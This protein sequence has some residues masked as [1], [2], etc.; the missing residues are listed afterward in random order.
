MF[1]VFSILCYQNGSSQRIVINEI[2]ASNGSTIRDE[3]GQFEDYIELFN[4]DSVSI[5]LE[6]YHISDNLG[7]PTKWKFPS[8]S[9]NP[10][11]FL[12]VFASSKNRFSGPYLHTNF[13]ISANG[14]PITLY[15]PNGLVA[16]HIPSIAIPRDISY[17]RFV[18]G[19]DSLVFFKVPTPGF[20]NLFANP[21]PPK[22]RLNSDR[23]SGFY[24]K[25]FSLRFVGL[26]DSNLVIY[27]TMDGSNP[28]TTSLLY[29]DSIWIYDRTIDSNSISLIRTNAERVADWLKWIPPSANLFKGTTLKAQGFIGDSAATSIAHYSFFI[30][31]LAHQRYTL[32]VFSILIPNEAF[33]DHD[34]GIYVPGIKD[35]LA[36]DIPDWDYATGNYFN[37]GSEWERFG[38]IV[39]WDTSGQIGFEQNIGF[40][41]HGG[42]SRAQP[43]KSLRLYSGRQYGKEEINYPFFADS[44]INSF[45]RILLRNGGQ[46][47]FKTFFL[48]ALTHEIIKPL[49]VDL[50]NY[51]PSIVFINGEYWGIHNIRERIDKYF[52]ANH[53][54][55]NPENLDMIAYSII[56]E[57][58]EG[59]Y[60]FYQSNIRNYIDANLNRLNEPAVYNYLSQVIDFDNYLDYM[61]SKM[62]FGVLDWMG[63]N[64]RFWRERRTGS[65][66]RWI[67]FDNDD[68]LQNPFLNSLELATTEGY[69]MWPNPDYSTHLFRNLIKI[70]RFK[71]S[72]ITRFERNLRNHF[73]LQRIDS[74]TQV[75]KNRIA[76]EMEEHIVRWGY[77]NSYENWLENVNELSEKFEARTLYLKKMLIEYFEIDDEKYLD[78]IQEK[79]GVEEVKTKKSLT[80]FPNPNNGSFSINI[81][82]E[83]LGNQFEVMSVLDLSGKTIWKAKASELS[84][85]DNSTEIAINHLLKSGVYIVKFNNGNEAMFGR[86][87]VY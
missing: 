16:D 46:E 22:P 77:P 74:I 39:F 2:M 9:V 28:S 14:E 21:K 33:F 44:D 20:S 43:M 53:H 64:V 83:V 65:K 38:H 7:Q 24:S 31:S 1:L 81:P 63:N 34:T 85:R 79:V 82:T 42:G 25:E 75:F 32:P 51:T 52:I 59:S 10:G 57:E 23:T 54:P 15:Y 49:N 3:D 48:D 56:I 4:A 40:R 45:K 70:D 60:N 12:L 50:Q 55:V 18:D 69:D 27:Y 68:A 80:I 37:T 66:F 61:T 26:P 86:L 17:G 58:E 36:E 67:S 84:F 35:E 11:E 73:S 76:P 87:V 6:N 72:F 29:E 71:D 62:F 47:F 30:D 19:G 8:I 13:N 41:I 78:F 5:N